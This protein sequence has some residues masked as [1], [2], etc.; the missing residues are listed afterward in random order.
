MELNKRYTTY[1]IFKKNI[2]RIDR[3]LEKSRGTIFEFFYYGIFEYEIKD[4]NVLL[5]KVIGEQSAMA[6]IYLSK[7]NNYNKKF[8]TK[9]M[10]LSDLS[11]K[12]LDI[13][14]HLS[15][16][17]YKTKNIH[18]PLLYGHSLCNEIKEGIKIREV[19]EIEEKYNP[20]NSYYSLF[21]ELYEGSMQI[22]LI[23]LARN[24]LTHSNET[25]FKDNIKNVIMQCFI[26]I[27][28]CHIN[29]VY[30]RDS[31]LNNFLYQKSNLNDYFYNYS[32]EYSYKDLKF[33]LKSKPF[34]ISICDFGLSDYEKNLKNSADMIWVN[35][36]R[37]EYKLFR[38]DYILFLNS[39]NDNYLKKHK[40]IMNIL[41]LDLLYELLEKSNDDYEF[42]KHLIENKLFDNYEKNERII[43]IN[44][45]ST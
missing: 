27:L 15:N 44:L 7:L 45:N 35:K 36:Y 37:P 42:F 9:I 33:N 10:R 19:N 29:V 13:T 28:T 25:T 5:L 21:I 23:T 43:E 32:Y 12:E 41:N 38:Q 39:L 20:K 18:L 16:I 2:P 34:I 24:L 40:L 17:A 26:S 14:D 4:L 22:L 8:V 11:I 1:E 6:T 30:H 31:H 3:C